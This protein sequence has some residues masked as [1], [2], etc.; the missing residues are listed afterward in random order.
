[1]RSK[2]LS[3]WRVRQMVS[4][5]D[6]VRLMMV[7]YDMFHKAEEYRLYAKNIKAKDKCIK[8]RNLTLAE[9]AGVTPSKAGN[10]LPLL[11]QDMGLRLMEKRKSNRSI[12]YIICKDEGD[13]S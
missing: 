9:K 3:H 12:T 8:I 1:M 4:N 6:R 13:E 10:L 2:V 5:A 7:I 11:L